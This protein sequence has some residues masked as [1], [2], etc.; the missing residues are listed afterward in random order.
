MNM[1]EYLLKRLELLELFAE[2]GALT[3]DARAAALPAV[4]FTASD[5]IDFS[6]P[7]SLASGFGVGDELRAFSFTSRASTACS[8]L[9]GDV[10]SVV[11][12]Q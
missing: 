10:T 2:K 12:I 8:V 1:V 6:D 9:L 11:P 7:P 4:L 3:C 5:A